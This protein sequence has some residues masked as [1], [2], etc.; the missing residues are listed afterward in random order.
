MNRLP[1]HDGLDL[2]FAVPI[3]GSGYEGTCTVTVL[4]MITG[5][6]DILDAAPRVTISD[7]LVELWTQAP[8]T[9]TF[10]RMTDGTAAAIP[11]RVSFDWSLGPCDDTRHGICRGVRLDGVLRIYGRERT[12]IYRVT[13]PYWDLPG[14]GQAYYRGQWPD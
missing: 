5:E 12:V 13:G 14:T 6:L 1:H 11:G 4:D 10:A 7:Q 2:H 9:A 3:T 8:D